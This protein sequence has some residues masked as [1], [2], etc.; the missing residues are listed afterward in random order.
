MELTAERDERV[1]RLSGGQQRRLAMAIALAGDPELLFLDEPTTGFDP[2]ARREAWDVV[3]NLAASSGGV[4]E[5]PGRRP[6][7]GVG[8]PTAAGAAA[9][10]SDPRD[11]M[12]GAGFSA[13]VATRRGRDRITPADDGSN[14]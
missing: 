3:K 1:V 11:G 6:D 13:V 10:R 2:S 5:W 14:L 7:V 12:F 8:P 4:L 9:K